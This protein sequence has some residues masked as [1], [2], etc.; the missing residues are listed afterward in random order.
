ME[1]QEK[2]SMVHKNL[3]MWVPEDKYEVIKKKAAKH[4]MSIS[5]YCNRIMRL[6]MRV[7]GTLSDEEAEIFYR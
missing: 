1:V 6:G 7:E 2:T 5:A 4:E 3:Q